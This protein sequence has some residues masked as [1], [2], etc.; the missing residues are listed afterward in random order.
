MKSSLLSMRPLALI[1]F[2]AAS[3]SLASCETTGDPT[4]G[5][6]FG[7]SESKAQGRLYQ[8]E[9]ELNHVRGNTQQV[10]DQNRYLE[11]RRDGLRY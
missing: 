7:W 5:G 9:A 8:K 3:L 11:G 1:G 10:Q 2:A 4:Q 6:L